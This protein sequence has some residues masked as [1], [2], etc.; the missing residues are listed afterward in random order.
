[1]KKEL[2][3][4]Y[5]NLDW[6]YEEMD[7]LH[8]RINDYIFFGNCDLYSKKV[9]QEKLQAFDRE[10]DELKARFEKEMREIEKLAGKDE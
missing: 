9:N 6:L 1:M 2:E 8:E 7:E 10:C 4:I 5:K 3:I